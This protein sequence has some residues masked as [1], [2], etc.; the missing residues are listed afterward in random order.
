ME[1]AALPLE[2][3]TARQEEEASAH[4]EEGASACQEVV[5]MVLPEAGTVLQEEVMVPPEAVKVLPEEADTVPPAEA[6]KVRLEAEKELPEVE[7]VTVLPLTE[8]KQE[9]LPLW[10]GKYNTAVQYFFEIQEITAL[11]GNIPDRMGFL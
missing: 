5:V 1:E 8:V 4:L 2:E 10:D 9:Q 3:V 11:G 6:V 7:A